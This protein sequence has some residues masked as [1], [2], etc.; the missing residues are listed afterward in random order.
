MADGAADL[1]QSPDTTVEAREVFGI[2]L[3]WRVP[4]FS[5]PNRYTPDRDSSYQFDPE[6]TRAILAGFAHNR[7]VMIQG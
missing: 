7:R 5:R 6:T 1:I 3:D 2:D 4:A